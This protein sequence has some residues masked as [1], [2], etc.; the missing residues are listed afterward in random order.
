M[1]NYFLLGFSVDID[2]WYFH[3]YEIW[4][5]C[6][7]VFFGVGTVSFS[8][9]EY[10]LGH[11]NIFGAFFENLFWV[12]FLCVLTRLTA[13]GLIL[14]LHFS[15]VFFSGLSIHISQ[16]ILAHL[17][18]CNIT[19]GATKKEVERSNFWME[20]PKILK[21]FWVSSVISTLCILTV[22]VFSTTL[23]PPEWRVEKSSWSLFLPLLYAFPLL[24]YGTWQRLILSALSSINTGCHLLYPVSDQ[25]FYPTCFLPLKCFLHL[26]RAEP[27]VDDFLL[28]ILLRAALDAVLHH[29]STN[30]SPWLLG[31]GISTGYFGSKRP[32]ASTSVLIR[33]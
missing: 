17:F 11:R 23:V 5:A 27:V 19:W 3:S 22:V 21:R 7:V 30:L 25:M 9:L 12:P 20:V 28:L 10:R 15:F 6:T 26:D 14:T 13:C 32:Q 4:F 31:K 24:F 1:L 8:L 16:V 29:P 2:G 33:V 18:S